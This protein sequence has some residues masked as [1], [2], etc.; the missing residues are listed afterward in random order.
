MQTLK[1]KAFRVSIQWNVL[2]RKLLSL[3]RGALTY[4]KNDSFKVVGGYFAM[5]TPFNPQLTPLKTLFKEP[6]TLAFFRVLYKKPF[7]HSHILD[8]QN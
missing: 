7:R 4:S 3:E 5:N 8:A 1:N 6:F 2:V